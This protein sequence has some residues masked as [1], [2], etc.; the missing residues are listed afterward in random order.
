MIVSSLQDARRNECVTPPWVLPKTLVM[1]V[2]LWA[3]AYCF[4]IVSLIDPAQAQNGPAAR[5][6]GPVLPGQDSATIGHSGFKVPIPEIK[7]NRIIGGTAAS[8]P[9]AQPQAGEPQASGES[10]EAPLP[11]GVDRPASPETSSSPSTSDGGETSAQ[12]PA[13]AP[14]PLITPP[15]ETVPAQSPV[16]PAGGTQEKPT[17]GPT[18]NSQEQYDTAPRSGTEETSSARPEE[19]ASPR[20]GIQPGTRESEEHIEMLVRAPKAPE[21]AI[22]PPPP[23]RKEM[24]RLDSPPDVPLILKNTPSKE[25]PAPLSIPQAEADDLADPREWIRLEQRR[26]PEIIPPAELEP[27]PE[28]PTHALGRMQPMEESERIPLQ[29]DTSSK[30]QAPY[31]TFPGDTEPQSRRSRR[32][33][34]TEEHIPMLPPEITPEPSP[35]RRETKESPA[36]EA[37]TESEVEGLPPKEIVPSVEETRS[38]PKEVL[39]SP[40]NDDVLQS[41]EVRDYLLQAAPILEELSL[42]M[43]T[44]PSLNLADYDPSDPSAPAIPGD[45]YLRMDAIKRQLQILDSKT[46]AIIPPKKYGGFHS[47]I[48]ESIAETNQACTAIMSYLQKSN[49]E[50]L[51]V[52]RDHLLRARKLIQ[53][54]REE[55]DKG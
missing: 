46:F 24:L 27:L 25:G 38:E 22:E 10:P 39:P 28:D 13:P 32:S 33:E 8:V 16:S 36:P 15:R 1:I 6:T 12:S 14:E 47:L 45:I 21:D 7:M 50:D 34:V 35:S 52:I 19:P 30:L 5:D 3:G 31:S 43:T 11:P 18:R 2:I 37:P 55:S 17:A 51:R 9:E 48:R 41:R 40:L 26:E 53:R 23:P 44:A 42:L 29:E 54:T 20:S 4:P 49:T